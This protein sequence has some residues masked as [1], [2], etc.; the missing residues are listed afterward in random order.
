MQNDTQDNFESKVEEMVEDTTNEAEEA[1]E[2]NED[3]TEEESAEESDKSSEIEALS[4]KVRELEAQKKH[5]KEK[6]TKKAEVKTEEGLSQSDIITLAKSDVHED[7]ISE[8][9]EYAKLKNVSVKDALK[10]SVVKA[11]IRDNK[12][13]RKTAEVTN[14]GTTRK[15]SPKTDPD[16]LIQMARKGELPDDPADIQKMFLRMKGIDK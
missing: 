2:P 11:I 10:S 4:K 8:V 3:D 5:W 1:E 15:A 13:S 12:E 9:L 6:A 7:D 14:T 16:A